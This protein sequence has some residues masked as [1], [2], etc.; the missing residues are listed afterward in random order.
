MSDPE[1]DRI[2]AEKAKKMVAVQSQ[3]TEQ[4]I[5][6]LT[7]ANFD[8]QIKSPKPTFVDYWASWCGP[9]KA[10]EPVVERLARRFSGRVSFGKLNVDEQPEVATRY[11]VQSI[12]T[13]MIFK[14]GAPVDAAIGAVPEA[15]LEQRIRKVLGS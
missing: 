1:L 3:P 6:E 13:F 8:G 9:C 10:M 7:V 2:L 5:I 14:N 4:G 11:D 15:N 12:P